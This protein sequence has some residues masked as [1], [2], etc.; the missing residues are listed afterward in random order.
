M[1][2]DGGQ[3]HTAKRLKSTSAS[4]SGPV[5]DDPRGACRLRD[6]SI[7]DRVTPAWSKAVA[8]IADAE[9]GEEAGENAGEGKLPAESGVGQR[10]ASI[11]ELIARFRMT[12]GSLGHDQ[13]SRHVSVRLRMGV[14]VRAR[15]RTHLCLHV[16]LC[17]HVSVCIC[18]YVPL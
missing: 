6:G 15:E 3:T 10:R 8:P 5:A 12:A 16:C 4:G 11:T 1:Q 9:G 13:I 17:V 7:S 14:C 18:V 2:T